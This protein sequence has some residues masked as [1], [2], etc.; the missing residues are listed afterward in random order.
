MDAELPVALRP[1][2]LKGVR[3]LD[4]GQVI[5]LPF[6]TRWLAW[7]GAEVILVE[8][9]TRPVQRVTPPFAYG[10][11]GLNTGARFNTLNFNK[12]GCTLNLKSTKGRDLVR[13][14]VARSDAVVENFSSG[15]M[16]RLGLGYEELRRVNPSLV[17]LSASAF[18]QTGEWRDLS[19]FHSAVN[20]FSG[21][22]DITGYEGG[23]P[24]LL[25]AVLP[26]TIGGMYI[27]LALLVALYNRRR[28]GEGCYV[29]FSMLEGLLSVMPQ[30]IIDY[31]LN[32]RE[33]RRAGNRDAA[34]APHGIYRCNGDDRWV[35]ISVTS[36]D[37]WAALCNQAGRRDWLAD[38][39]FADEL[40]RAAHG[41]ELD[42]VL[43]AWTRQH[44]ANEVTRLL[45]QAGIAAGPALD[46]A[47][48]LADPHLRAR[49]FVVEVDHPEAGPRMTVGLPWKLGN[50]ADRKYTHAP[51]LGEHN[52]YVFGELLGLSD[53]EI[54]D[55]IN[56]KVIE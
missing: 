11:R 13:R 55:L 56:E 38:P 29:D 26:D 39:R 14:L 36:Q 4:L 27:A 43:E 21:L 46:V 22:A 53:D 47:E 30:P 45:Q 40:T 42:E 16:Q 24:R 5:L 52:R 1:Q 35:A 28:T 17:Y 49:D 41:R 32:G 31:T 33:P 10:R 12:T 44:A 51:L 37:E 8:S 7:M 6:A 19:G 34:K 48:L 18:G 3:I 54:Q 9:G 23:P 20:A 50:V 2:A 15:T 25:G